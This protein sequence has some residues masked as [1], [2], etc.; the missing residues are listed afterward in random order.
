MSDDFGCSSLC[1]LF[2]GDAAFSGQV[3]RLTTV[4]QL[5]LKIMTKGIVTESLQL[6]QLKGFST[7]GTVHVI[8]NNQIGFTTEPKDSRSGTYASDV[9]AMLRCPIFHVNG[10]AK[11]FIRLSFF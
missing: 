7:G 6:S 11:S 8:V 9:A 4:A 5:R 3:S 10:T 1:I 2:H